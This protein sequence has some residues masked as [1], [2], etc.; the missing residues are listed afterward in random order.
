MKTLFLSVLILISLSLSA[1]QSEVYSQ[2][3]DKFCQF[4]I[5]SRIDLLLNNNLS[6]H[7]LFNL[8]KE[9]HSITRSY[10]NDV[11]NGGGDDRPLSKKIILYYMLSFNES[12][13]PLYS[14]SEIFQKHPYE[15]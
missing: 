4:K 5:T 12:I 8:D 11:Q 3:C 14:I 6:E 1:K 10:I 7:R 9:Y 15:I 13:S 2:N